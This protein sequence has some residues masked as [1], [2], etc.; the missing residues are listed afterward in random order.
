MS[1]IFANWKTTSAGLAAICG[2]LGDIFTALGHGQ[3]TGNLSVDIAAI[4]A[5]V[6]LI[7]AGDASASK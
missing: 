4:G 3:L 5:G 1:A 2:A 7:F 6:G